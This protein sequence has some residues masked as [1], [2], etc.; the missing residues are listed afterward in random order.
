MPSKKW[1]KLLVTD[2][3]LEW[4]IIIV[5]SLVHVFCLFPFRLVPLILEDLVDLHW[6]RRDSN[7]TQNNA[8]FIVAYQAL[9][10]VMTLYKPITSDPTMVVNKVSSNAEARQ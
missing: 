8:P 7:L 3:T 6:R 1:C 10:K 2:I 5:D 4:L 9:C